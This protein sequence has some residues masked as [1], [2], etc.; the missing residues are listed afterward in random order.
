VSFSEA[1]P[2]D[3]DSPQPT[4]ITIDNERTGGL[5][6]VRAARPPRGFSAAE[7]LGDLQVPFV[8]YDVIKPRMPSKSPV[9]EA[10]RDL[11]SVQDRRSGIVNENHGGSA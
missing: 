1:S 6:W 7:G 11:D 2:L 9:F 8:K 4:E 10:A 5:K 3:A